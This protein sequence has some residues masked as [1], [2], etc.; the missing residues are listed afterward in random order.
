MEQSCIPQG[1]DERGEDTREGGGEGKRER[2]SGSGEWDWEDDGPF[3][4]APM[5]PP[6]FRLHLL[7]CLLLT[8]NLFNL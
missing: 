8:S 5:Q 2:G 7:S 1:S 6:S 4:V 3:K